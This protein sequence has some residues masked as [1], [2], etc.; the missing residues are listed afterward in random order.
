MQPPPKGPGDHNLWVYGTII[1]ILEVAEGIKY[2]CSFMEPWRLSKKQFANGESVPIDSGPEGKGVPILSQF[3]CPIFPHQMNGPQIPIP[4]DEQEQQ[5][6]EEEEQ[7]QEEEQQQ[8][9]KEGADEDY[10]LK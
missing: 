4:V 7:E 5:E 2:M 6:E 10:V 8:E 1:S 3:L 9:E